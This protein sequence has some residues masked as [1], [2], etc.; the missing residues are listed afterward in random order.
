MTATDSGVR[1]DCDRMG[2]IIDVLIF[3]LNLLLLNGESGA[4]M[5]ASLT[6]TK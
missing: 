3:L 4:S 6:R 5:L 1:F 2:N